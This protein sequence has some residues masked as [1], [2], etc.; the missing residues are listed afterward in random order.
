MISSLRLKELMQSSRLWSTS[1]FTGKIPRKGGRPG[2]TYL[3]D[4]KGRANI[5]RSCLKYSLEEAAGAVSAKSSIVSTSSCKQTPFKV[6]KNTL[7]A[8]LMPSP[9]FA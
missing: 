3:I 9:D 7:T 6:L 8:T 4:I 5:P 2:A 1:H